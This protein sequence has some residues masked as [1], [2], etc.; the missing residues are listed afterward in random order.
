MKKTISLA[1]AINMISSVIA[2]P[3]V[4]VSAANADV[5]N[6]TAKVDMVDTVGDVTDSWQVV[7]ENAT[8]DSSKWVYD[9]NTNPAGSAVGGWG[10]YE[11][12]KDIIVEPS[13]AGVYKTGQ[14]Y[15]TGKISNPL[16]LG[17]N[18]RGRNGMISYSIRTDNQGKHLQ[19]I[20]GEYKNFG[21]TFDLQFPNMIPD[22][23]RKS[24]VEIGIIDSAAAK[25]TLL[26]KYAA[27]EYVSI[28]NTVD[29]R[30]FTIPSG[31]ANAEIAP[32]AA[33]IDARTVEEFASD[34]AANKVSYKAGSAVTAVDA[35]TGTEY[36]QSYENTD[37]TKQYLNQVINCKLV[38]DGDVMSLYMKF[39][40]SQTWK[41]INS[42]D[43][44][45][46]RDKTK[47]FYITSTGAQMLVSNLNVWQR[48]SEIVT[49]PIEPVVPE[50]PGTNNDGN[51]KV[52]LKENFESETAAEGVITDS[53]YD[54]GNA[55]KVTGNKRFDFSQDSTYI[56]EN[57]IFWTMT[58]FDIK[59]DDVSSSKYPTITWTGKD[60]KVINTLNFK[61]NYVSLPYV[62]DSGYAKEITYLKLKSGEWNRIRLV[63]QFAKET[64][65]GEEKYVGRNKKLYI[66]GNNVLAVIAE[67]LGAQVQK[68]TYTAEYNNR[69]NINAGGATVYVDN[70]T[71]TRFYGEEYEDVNYGQ[72]LTS[73]RKGEKALDGAV[74]GTNITNAIY[75]N[76]KTALDNAKAAYKST[77]TQADTE[78]ANDTL[79]KE[80]SKLIFADDAYEICAVNFADR[81]GGYA[82]Y[83]TAGGKITSVMIRKNAEYDKSGI[84]ILALYDAD[85]NL[86]K[87][88]PAQDVFNGVEVGETKDVTFN[89]ELPENIEGIYIK[90]MLLDDLQN[91]TPL[92]NAYVPD[93]TT[94]RNI[95][96]AGDSIVHTYAESEKLY[97]RQGW[98]KYAANYFN[99]SIT[100]QNEAVS[101]CTTRTFIGFNFFN[102]IESKIKEGDVLYVS[103]M[104]N[105]REKGLKYV[106]KYDYKNM[107]AMDGYL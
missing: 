20:D 67:N 30:K 90:V 79:C 71:I 50:D 73:I 97:P 28:G 57:R 29:L 49:E 104:E 16:K 22:I 38:A 96:I 8:S 14:M 76:Y 66:N 101:G 35:V 80:Y 70:L 26:T 100:A 47:R 25:N 68:D 44:S 88:A 13:S 85:G 7:A 12:S 42:Y 6:E 102:R 9:T 54:I 99:D 36:I 65:N 61:D 106:S 89:M 105:D 5:V 59:M 75:D 1:I 37:G 19:Y 17:A 34:A 74:V 55:L 48:E 98:G 24:N 10:P 41:H 46:L 95:Y 40:D 72:L 2:V 91:I 83:L 86:I 103:F 21:I 62:N 69:F 107:L 60:D 64:K 45:A 43:I 27:D 81:N 39:E 58:E 51:R 52:V 3:N 56:N 93:N 92:T 32:R 53:A 94:Q 23:S 63:T 77:P 84:L 31:I 82:P 87:V 15:R 33:V 18:P 4:M 78:I 11:Y